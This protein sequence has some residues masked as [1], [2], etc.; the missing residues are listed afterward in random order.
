MPI[1]L[2]SRRKGGYSCFFIAPMEQ[3]DSEER[4]NADFVLN[5]LLRPVLAQCGFPEERI[6][7]S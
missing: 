6:V 2:F 3:P 5:V 1:G 4:N 7:R